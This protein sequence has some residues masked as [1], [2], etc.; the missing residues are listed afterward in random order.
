MKLVR[1]GALLGSLVLLVATFVSLLHEREQIA[2]ATDD[3]LEVV[4]ITAQNSIENTLSRAEA[5]IDVAG[6]DTDPVVLLESFGD[7][8]EACIDGRCTGADLSTLGAYGSAISALDGSG[9][10]AVVDDETDSV[11]LVGRNAVGVVAIVLASTELMD[12]AAQA[13]VDQLAVTAELTVSSAASQDVDNNPVTVEHDRVITRELTAPLAEG[14]V[15]FT[16]SLPGDIGWG[17]NNPGTYILLFAL[18]TLLLCVAVWGFSTESQKL[19]RRATTDE[20]TGLV[21]RREF[22]R[23]SDEAIDMAER[24]NTGLA[25]MV[26]DLNGFKQINDTL[27]HHVGDTVLSGCADRLNLAVRD[28]DVVGRWGGDEFV[29]L[30]PGLNDASGVRNSAERIGSGL[31]STPFVDNIMMTGSI[32]AALYPRHGKTLTELMQ[33]ADV[34]MYEAKTTGVVHRLASSIPPGRELPLPT[35]A[36]PERRHVHARDDGPT[37]REP[38]R[39]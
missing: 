1:V 24:F 19:E 16:A 23:I 13:F 25:I 7:E 29:V 2:E 8:A 34:A 39:Q 14:A 28:T 12:P 5:V 27:G 26:I 18:G 37:T 21:N 20:L 6:A 38:T 9:S 32:G 22:E 31:S 11:L 10:V 17:G 3:R 36:G 4:A 30:L 35:Y 33:A 15:T